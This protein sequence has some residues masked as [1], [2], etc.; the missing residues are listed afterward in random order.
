MARIFGGDQKQANTNGVVTCGYMAPDYAMQGIFSVKSY[1]FGF[2]VLLLE[3]I[4]GKRRNGG[5]YLSGD[6]RQSLLTDDPINRPTMSAI[7]VMLAS[8][9][10]TIPKPKQPAFSVG[11][12]DQALVSAG[13]YGSVNDMTIS[14]FSPR[15]NDAMVGKF[16]RSSSFRRCRNDVYR[17]QI[18]LLQVMELFWHAV[19]GIVH[20]SGKVGP[21]Q[22]Q[23]TGLFHKDSQRKVNEE[24]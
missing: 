4:A 8:D 3:I 10:M 16:I 13:S 19:A 17:L 22:L 9:T 18:T 2:G 12:K 5:F 7:V 14:S 11:R 1:G 6:G 20:C 23:N 21:L 15:C 24:V